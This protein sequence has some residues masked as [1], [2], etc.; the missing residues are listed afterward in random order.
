MK[1]RGDPS[2]PRMIVQTVVC[3]SRT[4]ELRYNRCG[5]TNCQSC[6][7]RSLDYSGPPG[8][9]PYWYLCVTRKGRSKRIYI[10][11]TLDTSRWVLPDGSI[12]WAGFNA[13]KKGEKPSCDASKPS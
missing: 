3:S 1:H 6:Y 2:N 12:D 11:K 13:R 9:G 5:K 8:H 4:Y 7:H 10:G